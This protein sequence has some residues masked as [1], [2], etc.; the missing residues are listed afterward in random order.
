MGIAFGISLFFCIVFAIVA[1]LSRRKKNSN[2]KKDIPLKD[3]TKTKV[4]LNKL[5]NFF[6]VEFTSA[7]ND[8]D[9]VK[10]P[11]EPVIYSSTG[12][13][14]QFPVSSHYEEME[15]NRQRDAGLGPDYV[16][17]SLKD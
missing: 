5:V 7:R 9:Y 6:F 17:L 13:A 8:S 15:M 16:Q 12:L 11:F 1:V 3:G 4:F 10:G 2:E 14:Q